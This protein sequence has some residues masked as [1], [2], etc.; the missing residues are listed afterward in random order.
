MLNLCKIKKCRICGL[1]G[2]FPLIY[3][4][5]YILVF[6]HFLLHP[7]TSGAAGHAAGAAGS[8]C[9]RSSRS[10]RISMQPEQPGRHTAG[11][12]EQICRQVFD[13]VEYFVSACL[14]ELLRD[15][16]TFLILFFL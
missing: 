14:D 11:S 10:S 6:L 16:I 13:R 4:T 12:A 1:F 5:L 9:S 8:V 2:Y 3:G 15:F 7:R